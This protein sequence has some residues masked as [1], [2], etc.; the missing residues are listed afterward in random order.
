MIR[1]SLRVSVT[2][3]YGYHS[4]SHQDTREHIKQ[5]S[6][7]ITK[8]KHTVRQYCRANLLT[9]PASQTS[10]RGITCDTLCPFLYKTRTIQQSRRTTRFISSTPSPRESAHAVQQV[11]PATKSKKPA[12]NKGFDFFRVKSQQAEENR[13]RVIESTLTSEERRIF[14][15]I[16]RT[17]GADVKVIS[18]TAPPA[19]KTTTESPH[20]S[21]S[22]APKTVHPDLYDTNANNILSLF[23]PTPAYS[24]PDTEAATAPPH[25][26][27]EGEPQAREPYPRHLIRAAA[28]KAL[29][30]LSNHIKSVLSA[31][32]SPSASPRSPTSS[33]TLQQ[34]RLWQITTERIFPL[35]T[36]LQLVRI[37][38]VN[39]QNLPR[40]QWVQQLTIGDVDP[41]LVASWGLSDCPDVP[42]LPLV[43]ILYP[44]A[45][46]LVLRT[47]A[48]HFASSGYLLAL[49]PKIKDL[50]PTSYLLAGNVHLYNTLLQHAWDV[51]S[52]LDGM[53]RLL[54][55]M[56]RD[57]VSLD[58]GTL[59]VLDNVREDRT[60]DTAR[61]EAHKDYVGRG[62]RWWSMRAHQEDFA[63]VDGYWRGLVERDI[64]AKWL[65]DQQTRLVE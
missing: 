46:V 14:E 43:S 13:R 32:N 31:T 2:A 29:S 41:S 19:S 57:G 20:P 18:D 16:R 26:D 6:R 40:N 8:K 45:T 27:H 42:L 54:E 37:D 12:G 30:H 55:D 61:D 22:T 56:R 23:A 34:Q 64:E 1:F 63:R 60:K 28:L 53:N 9:M 35:V 10:L 51:Y 62:G 65:Q 5:N 36:L 49:L 39:S 3:W 21:P 47:F 50:G 17:F 59:Q 44:A 33:D 7:I 48:R 11:K 58:E 24:E 38:K 4:T 25:L 15:N 52:D